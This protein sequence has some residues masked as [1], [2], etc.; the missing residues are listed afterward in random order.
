MPS[1]R[2][3]RF[4]N[5]M[6]GTMPNAFS[7]GIKFKRSYIGSRPGDILDTNGKMVIATSDGIVLV[8][9]A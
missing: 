3:H 1:K 2:V 5:A 6:S 8:E 7:S 4:I 9:P